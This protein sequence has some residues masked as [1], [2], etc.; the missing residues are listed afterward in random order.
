MQFVISFYICTSFCH[1]FL[2]R[3]LLLIFHCNEYFFSLSQ[4]LVSKRETSFVIQTSFCFSSFVN[5]LPSLF[6]LSRAHLVTLSCLRAIYV[7]KRSNFFFL[8]TFRHKKGEHFDFC[9][10]CCSVSLVWCR[11]FTNNNN[12]Q[13][14]SIQQSNSVHTKPQAIS[15]SFFNSTIS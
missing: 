11:R 13:I 5:S 2:C 12:K 8:E 14:V 15:T 10:R 7:Y 9:T 1:F 3:L 6:S 4:C